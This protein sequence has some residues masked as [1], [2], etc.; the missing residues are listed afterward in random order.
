MTPLEVTDARQKLADTINRVAYGKER[1]LLRRRGKD[2][3]A[4]VPVEDL[5]LLEELEDRSDVEAAR[6][7]LAESK[8]RIPYEQARRSLGLK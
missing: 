2:M 8:R 1:I 7:A 6:A 3:A 5:A 4:L